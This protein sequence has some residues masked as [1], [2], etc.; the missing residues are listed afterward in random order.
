MLVGV[1]SIGGLAGCSQAGSDAS[2]EIS[3]LT[4]YD[5]ALKQAQA[6]NKLVVIDFYA[7]WCSYCKRMD[8]KTFMDSKVQQRLAGFVPLKI[9]TDKQPELAKKYGV[10]GL[11]T[12]VVIDASGKPLAGGVGYLEPDRYLSILDGAKA[13]NVETNSVK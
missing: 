11:P 4:D 6:T 7:P 12:M 5:A 1:M 3:W 8:K 13:K 2:S 9:D 10:E